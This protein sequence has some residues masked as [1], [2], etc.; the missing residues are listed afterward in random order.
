MDLVQ[1]LQAGQTD[2]TH[3]VSLRKNRLDFE[4]LLI[5]QQLLDFL[6]RLLLWPPSFAL[7]IFQALCLE[8]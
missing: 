5:R 1:G 4:H 3:F 2:K 8:L 7:L 6:G